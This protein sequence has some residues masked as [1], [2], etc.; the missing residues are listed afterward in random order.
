MLNNTFNTQINYVASESNYEN[1]NNV[2]YL[3]KS[4]KLKYVNTR[5]FSSYKMTYYALVVS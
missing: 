4:E 1:E 5:N 3:Q 2:I